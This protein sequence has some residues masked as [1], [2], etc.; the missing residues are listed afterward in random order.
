MKTIHLRII[1]AAVSLAA[2]FQSAAMADD[3]S[4]GDGDTNWR[5]HFRSTKSSAEVKAQVLQAREQ[6]QL[7]SFN[8]GTYP[9]KS[10]LRSTRS[11]DEVQREAIAANRSGQALADD[12]YMGYQ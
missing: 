10:T 2:G 9:G 11:R 6:G 5:E 8:D 1:I 12:N 7:D 4:L 3:K